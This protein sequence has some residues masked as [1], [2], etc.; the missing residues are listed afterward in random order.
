MTDSTIAKKERSPLRTLY[1]LDALRGFAAISIVIHHFSQYLLPQINNFA[2]HFSPYFVKSYLWVDF[3][4][5]LTGFII[6][7]VY[8]STF[9]K[10][11]SL[12][13][14]RSFLKKRL[15]RL[16]P[17]HFIT[18]SYLIILELFK[19][20][21]FKYG[22]TIAEVSQTFQIPFTGKNS[23][24]SIFTNL[25]L[26]QSFQSWS[27]WNEPAWF[28][29]A[30]FFVYLS[31]PIA[32]LMSNR[33][34]FKG[35]VCLLG[36]ASTPLILLIWR[37]G[38]LDFVT[39]RSIVRALSDSFFGISVYLIF[40]S[41]RLTHY[42]IKKTTFFL[43]FFMVI[44]SI[45]LP[46]NHFI[47]IIMFSLLIL[48][49]ATSSYHTE[50]LS[51]NRILLYLGSISYSIFMTHWPIMQTIKIISLG[52]TNYGFHTHFNRGYES[53]L[54]LLASICLVIFVSH[55]TY[56]LIELPFKLKRHSSRF[57]IKNT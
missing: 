17:L 39:Y 21:L 6:A 46:I 41:G 24:G 42:F 53:I 20:L 16:Y 33:L 45:A 31:I 37:N 7:Y 1:S 10:S 34:S 50:F 13:D 49:G 22:F 8:G 11:I 35:N 14:Y 28:N 26:V 27:Y 57:E 23:I 38:T 43:I 52:T 5:I 54:A 15:L 18:L 44:I 25:F 12:R 48:S 51:K 29:S 3:F 47:T 32:I 36:L 9:T 30:L 55:A 40:R 56:H 19:V 2:Y 4:F